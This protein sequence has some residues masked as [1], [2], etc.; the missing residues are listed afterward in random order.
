[1]TLSIEMPVKLERYFK[2]PN[3]L[4]ASLFTLVSRICVSRENIESFTTSS[5]V[6]SLSFSL[7]VDSMF[8]IAE[9]FVLTIRLP[10]LSVN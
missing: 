4:V 1:M 2:G 8:R 6:D 5:L 10:F 7:A 9:L 3:S